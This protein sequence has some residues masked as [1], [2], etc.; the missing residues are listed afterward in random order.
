MPIF[1]NKVQKVD[2]RNPGAPKLWY[3]VIKSTK[4]VGEKELAKKLTE[5]TTLNSKEAEMAVHQLFKVIPELLSTS[6]TVQLGEMGSFRVTAETESST[7]EADVNA[8]KIKKLRVRFI[9]SNELKQVMQKTDVVD[10][11]ALTGK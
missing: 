4:L 5:E 10:L 2:P 8:S 3:P 6:H 9:E 1:Y 7:T 11:T